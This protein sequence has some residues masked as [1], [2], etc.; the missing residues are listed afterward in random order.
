MTP[1]ERIAAL[2][3]WKRSTEGWLGG[4]DRKLDQLIAAANMG[5]GAWWIVIKIGGL[6]VLSL[7]ALGWVLDHLGIARG[8]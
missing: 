7:G 2:E 3:E 8:S 6:V 5:K 1:E 4:M